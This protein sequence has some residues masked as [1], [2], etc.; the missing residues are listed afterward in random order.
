MFDYKVIASQTLFDRFGAKIVIDT[1][2][3]QGRQRPYFYLT[4]PVE[5]VATVGVTGEGQLILTRQYRHPIGQVIYD[6][7][8]GR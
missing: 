1:L 3:Y 4:S 2:E 6:L 5:A 8:A 7:P